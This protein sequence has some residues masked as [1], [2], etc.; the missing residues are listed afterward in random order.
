M[1][2]YNMDRKRLPLYY[3]FETMGAG[4]SGQTVRLRVRGWRATR[5][6]EPRRLPA[7]G[8]GRTSALWRRSGRAW[9]EPA[10]GRRETGSE[11]GL[12]LLIPEERR[13]RRP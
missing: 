12:G 9:P 6:A 11:I 2:L 13:R 7:M 10:I 8:G 3:V 5:P 4:H 1:S